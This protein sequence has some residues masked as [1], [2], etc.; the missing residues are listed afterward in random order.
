VCSCTEAV[1]V[2]R[3]GFWSL[4]C[5]FG[6]DKYARL[7]AGNSLVQGRRVSKTHVGTSYVLEIIE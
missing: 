5:G 6:G 4:L 1:V 3:V 2:L 7:F